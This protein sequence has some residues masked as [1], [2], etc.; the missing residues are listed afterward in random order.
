MTNVSTS[1]G[2]VSRRTVV[3]TG[4]VTLGA[5][6]LFTPA[7][8]SQPLPPET[9]D[10]DSPSGFGVEILNA[11]ATFPDT[12]TAKF[13]MQYAGENRSLVSNLMYDASTVVVAKVTWQPEGTSGWHTHPGPVIVSV[14]EGELELVN[15]RDCVPRTYTAGEAFIDPG[16]GNVH[17]ASNLSTSEGA[18]AYA[19]FLGVPDGGP[20]TVWVPPVDCRQ[21][22]RGA[23]QTGRG[24]NGPGYFT[25]SEYGGGPPVGLPSLASRPCRGTFRSLPTPL[26]RSP[27]SP[28]PRRR[29]RVRPCRHPPPRSPSRSRGRPWRS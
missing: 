26:R 21:P 15:E 29:R 25:E 28:R 12:V 17:I 23:R 13:R 7:A 1:N 8:A 3:K 2:G 4:A 9:Q 20:A 11:H 16:Q 5:L 19:T 6:G 24:A 27:R 22:G 10:V 18:V 14:A